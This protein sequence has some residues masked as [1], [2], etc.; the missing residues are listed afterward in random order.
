MVLGEDESGASGSRAA[1]LRVWRRV[2]SSASVR[3]LWG[4]EVDGEGDDDDEE[5]EEE[6]DGGVGGA[7]VGGRDQKG[8][9][10]CIRLSCV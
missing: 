3:S 5:E 10:R 7:A 2:V 9:V 4:F 1:V 8:M 6:E